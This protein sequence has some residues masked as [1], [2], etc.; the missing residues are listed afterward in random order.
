MLVLE[1]RKVGAL[2]AVKCLH[3]QALLTLFLSFYPLLLGG[4]HRE[5]SLGCTQLD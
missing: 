2:Q 5:W 3:V 4:P 1:Q